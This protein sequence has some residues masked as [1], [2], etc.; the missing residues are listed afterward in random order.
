MEFATIENKME[1]KKQYL[2]IIPRV[3]ILSLQFDNFE[4][5][6][7]SECEKS[8][9]VSDKLLMLEMIARKIEI[10]PKPKI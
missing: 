2:L 10:I 7:I 6:L 9:K 8:D 4:K 1:D 3:D 5:N